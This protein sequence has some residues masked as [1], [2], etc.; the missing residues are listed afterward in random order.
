MEIPRGEPNGPVTDDQVSHGV[1]PSETASVAISK[2]AAMNRMVDDLL[3]PEDGLDPLP[4]EDENIPPTPPEQTFEDTALIN[5]HSYGITPATVGDYVNMVRNY[6]QAS[7]TPEGHHRNS[8]AS[9]AVRNLPSL[10]PLPNTSDIWSKTYEPPL[11]SAPAVPPGLNVGS[12]TLGRQSISHSRHASLNNSMNNFSWSP[13]QGSHGRL[14]SMAD[15]FGSSYDVTLPNSS[16]PH[17]NAFP[18]NGHGF[19]GQVLANPQ[20]PL[21]FGNDN[22]GSGSGIWGTDLSHSR[23]SFAHTPPNGQAG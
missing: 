1:A 18:G 21:F 19:N 13:N 16:Q 10:P 5:D 7:C 15:G 17:G 22:W 23:G 4:E 8:T 3:G 6:S 20:S 12:A 2:D 11:H 14:G 9:P